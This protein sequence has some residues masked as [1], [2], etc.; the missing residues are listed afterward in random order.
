MGGTG[1]QYGSNSKSHAK[2]PRGTVGVHG[3]IILKQI[4]DKQVVAQNKVA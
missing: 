1:R 2:R 3:R 4:L